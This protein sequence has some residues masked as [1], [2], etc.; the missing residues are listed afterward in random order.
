MSRRIVQFGTSRFLQAHVDLFV[1]EARLAGQDIGPISVVKTT[2][3]AERRGRI[4]AMRQ[5]AGFPV[6]IRGYRDG[7]VVD[8]TVQVR[9]VDQALTA[10]EDWPNILNLFAG[11]ADI[12]VSNVGERGYGIAVADLHRRFLSH[13]IPESFPA[14]LLLL[15]LARFEAGGKPFLVLPCELLPSNGRALRQ[16]LDR[17]AIAWDLPAQFS[18]WLANAVIF[19]DTLVD[20]IVS[21]EIEPVGAIAEPYALWAIRN[22]GFPPPL[23]HPAIVYTDDLERYERL[24]LHI[25]NLGHTVLAQTWIA[26]QRPSTETVRAILADPLID[27]RLSEI[28][29]EEVIPAFAVLGMGEEAARYVQ[30][31][32]ER[33][34][35]PFLDH[36]IADIAQNHAIKIERRIVA[37]LALIREHAPSMTLP[38]LTAIAAAPAQGGQPIL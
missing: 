3:G 19:A 5:P 30:T 33:F 32:R 35:N 2:P 36:R 17:L 11:G 28:Y 24:K 10:A 18:E 31:T 4:D 34:R 12:A 25:L 6:R 7:V 13:Q 23:L 29:D 15:L 37:L 20:R 14:K 21:Q 9:S 22:A 1:H 27:Q 38:R 16:Q 26:D 8:E